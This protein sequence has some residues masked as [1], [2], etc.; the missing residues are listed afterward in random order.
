MMQPTKLGGP[1]E[2]QRMTTMRKHPGHVRH[3][4]WLLVHIP[5]PSGSWEQIPQCLSE[6]GA[7]WAGPSSF[8]A[9]TA[10]APPGFGATVTS[11][12]GDILK[13][14]SQN[15]DKLWV[16]RRKGSA[17]S[18]LICLLEDGT[19]FVLETISV[20]RVVIEH[21]NLLPGY[22]PIDGLFLQCCGIA[23]SPVS[24]H[25]E[26][27]KRCLMLPVE[28]K[29]C[30]SRWRVSHSTWQTPKMLSE[31]LYPLKKYSRYLA[32]TSSHKACLFVV[33][34]WV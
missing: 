16:G 4:G 9:L 26:L 7:D 23:L 10:A 17:S 29:L 11:H 15:R 33:D 18:V 31:N 22:D 19:K 1:E 6:G 5:T 21:F 3:A 24:R 12:P 13:G 2:A 30:T 28:K 20:V 8:Q 25:L 32:S 34:G 27:G 14:A